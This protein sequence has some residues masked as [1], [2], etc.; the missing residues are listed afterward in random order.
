MTYAGFQPATNWAAELVISD[1]RAPA[2]KTDTV[3]CASR[4]CLAFLPRPLRGMQQPPGAS[5]PLR[6]MHQVAAHCLSL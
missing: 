2:E 1:D 4:S 6:G 3:A 5:R